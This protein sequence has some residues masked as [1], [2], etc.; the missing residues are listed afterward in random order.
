MV[1]MGEK[2]IK[3]RSGSK[4][5]KLN[6]PAVAEVMKPLASAAKIAN[7]GNII[8]LNGDGFDS[9]IFNKEP[10]QKVHIYQEHTVDVM[11][12]DFMVEDE[13]SAWVTF[14]RQV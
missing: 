2:R 7:K 12:V 9:Y 13:Y 5:G 10:K 14:R 3:F 4:L 8:M 11:G 6:F 1:N